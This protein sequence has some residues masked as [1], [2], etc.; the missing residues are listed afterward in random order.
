MG[1]KC[2]SGNQMVFEGSV[3]QDRLSSTS[4]D[5]LIAMCECQVPFYYIK[6]K[7]L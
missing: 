4:L 2:I 5:A 1:Y 7:T 6:I 3:D